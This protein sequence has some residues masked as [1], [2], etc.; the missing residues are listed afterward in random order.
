MSDAK[1]RTLEN[2]AT[3]MFGAGTRVEVDGTDVY[4][5]KPGADYAEHYVLSHASSE[6]LDAA[7]ARGVPLE[8]GTEIQ[9]LAPEPE[10]LEER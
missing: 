7:V 6:I 3:R 5:A 2:A 4:G 9:L 1:S 10:D 8:E